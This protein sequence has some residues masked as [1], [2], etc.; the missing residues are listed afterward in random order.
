[1]EEAQSACS[2][3]I[4]T[5]WDWKDL[6]KPA[7]SGAQVVDLKPFAYRR[8]DYRLKFTFTGAGTGID[9]LVVTHDIQQSQRVLPALAKG[10]NTIHFQTG[11]AESTITIE[12]NQNMD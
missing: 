8:Y 9:T 10:P 6:P 2:S 3:P 4:I 7:A 11:A 12:A 5:D 1:M